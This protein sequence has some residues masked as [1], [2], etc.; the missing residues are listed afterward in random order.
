MFPRGIGKS[1]SFLCP[2]S[3]KKISLLKVLKLP[4]IKRNQS[5]INQEVALL[6]S[7]GF[8]QTQVAIQV[9]LASSSFKK[10]RSAIV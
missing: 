5:R 10:D 4:R 9:K 7:K 8:L 3:I 2:Y 6:V 1:Y